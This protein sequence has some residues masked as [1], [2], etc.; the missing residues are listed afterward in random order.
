MQGKGKKTHLINNML[1]MKK[2]RTDIIHAMENK[3]H[4]LD[5]PKPERK[6]PKKRP[7]RTKKGWLEMGKR[8]MKGLAN[9]TPEEALETMQ[10][11]DQR[12]NPNIT[13]EERMNAS[14]VFALRAERLRR[15]GINPEEWTYFT[16]SQPEKFRAGHT[17]EPF[18]ETDMAHWNQ[19]LPE[20]MEL[21][22]VQG[23][24][25]STSEP[26]RRNGRETFVTIPHFWEIYIRIKPE[27]QLATPQAQ[28]EIPKES[29]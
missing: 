7:L 26:D 10:Y 24:I 13:E 21:F 18:A 12:F 11:L 16:S 9:L 27:G 6:E 14:T 28:I 2:E 3:D 19:Q 29:F 23:E 8:I 20:G 5:I 4:S 1:F 22:V 25:S 17:D 15:M